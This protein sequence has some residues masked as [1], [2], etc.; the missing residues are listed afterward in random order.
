MPIHLSNMNISL[1]PWTRTDVKAI[2]ASDESTCM[3]FVFFATAYHIWPIGAIGIVTL[4]ISVWG[5]LRFPG[6][7]MWLL[8]YGY[9]V[10]T[11]IDPTVT[12]IVFSAPAAAALLP[13]AMRMKHSKSGLKVDWTALLAGVFFI[14]MI[15]VSEI[16][17][18]VKVGNDQIMFSRVFDVILCLFVAATLRSEQ[19]RRLSIIALALSSIYLAGYC[20]NFAESRAIYSLYL[21]QDR[22]GGAGGLDPNYLSLYLAIGLGPLIAMTFSPSYF[23]SW[24]LRGIS[25]LGALSVIYAVLLTSSR[26]GSLLV[27]LSIVAVLGMSMVSKVRALVAVFA[28]TLIVVLGVYPLLKD[29]PVVAGL[30]SRWNQRSVENGSG[31][32]YLATDALQRFS[33]QSLRRILVGGGTEANYHILLGKNTHNAYL[34]FLLD[35]GIFGAAFFIGFLVNA[36]RIVLKQKS[37]PTNAGIIS[38]WLVLV[39]ASFVL[40]PFV[41]TLAWLALAPMVV[42]NTT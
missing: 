21:L 2:F 9:L 25:L 37:V 8:T 38:T 13:L 31:R 34:E 39:I 15:L 1:R 11:L 18:P 42:S 41:H 23:R 33:S 22:A 12:R 32:T 26:M 35:H 3:L 29:A 14:L 36:L 7:V 20:I 28:V 19:D 30:E 17:D 24:T 16:T 40:S 5:V 27:L 6:L 10:Q 4:C